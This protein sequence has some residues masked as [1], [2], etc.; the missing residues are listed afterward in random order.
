MPDEPIERHHFP[1]DLAEQVMR[2]WD[3]YLDGLVHARPPLPSAAQLRSLLE[4]AYLAGM[5]R[6]EGRSLRFMLCCTPRSAI[7]HRLG[8]ER[9]VE[10][11]P[12][13]AP[14]PF[15]V[16][17][18]RRLAVTT[19]VD[20]AALWVEFAPE[21]D[22]PLAVRGLLNLGSSWARA[23]RAFAYSYDALPEALLVRVEA[24][25][26]LTIFQGSYVVA[27]LR[28]GH[29]QVETP[30]ST[31]DL[32][33]A[34]PLFREGQKLLRSQITPPRFEVLRDWDQF[35]WLTYVNTILAIVNSIQAG[36]HGGAL[37][38]A[39]DACDLSR[40]GH[41][42]VKIKYR[43]AAD[44]T[45]LQRRFVEFMNIRHQY[46]DMVRQYAVDHAMPPQGQFSLGSLVD[47]QRKLAET[48]AFVGNLAA[49]DGALLLRSDLAVEGFGT[50]ILL[51]RVQQA[52]V[53]EIHN[54]FRGARNAYD[55]EQRGTRH[56]SAM[57]LC[58]A[59]PDLCVFVI[60]QDGGVSL[61]WNDNGEVCIK[62][63]IQTTGVFLSYSILV[64][65]RMV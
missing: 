29:I 22:A 26:H 54:P 59:V 30:L 11:W 25:G 17:E 45:H 51:D 52:P 9:I 31:S 3:A 7:V 43:L 46:G 62:S 55:A 53:Y 24:P 1:G 37:I 64:P 36:G 10:S 47:A 18:I 44:P 16:Q 48:C 39:A 65:M 28:S 20:T 35:E 27:T 6:E 5:E 41:E 60:S 21:P 12:F 56:R 2:V 13:G 32:L 61:I 34:Y 38:L 40:A 4:V 14:R 63:G 15:N 50:E 8:Q 42:L 57:R 58:A 49:A 23:R 33:G 19:D